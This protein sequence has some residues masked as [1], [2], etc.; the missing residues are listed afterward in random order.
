MMSLFSQGDIIYL[1]FNPQS[2]HEQKGRRSAIVITN[3]L[4][5][6]YSKIC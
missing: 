6:Q 5:S 3:N 1:D 2:G 4:F